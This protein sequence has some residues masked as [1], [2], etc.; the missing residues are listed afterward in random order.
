MTEQIRRL[1]EITLN[2]SSAQQQCFYD[3]WVLRFSPGS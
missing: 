1:E 3:G 2:S